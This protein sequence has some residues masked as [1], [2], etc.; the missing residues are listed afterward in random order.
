MDIK[1]GGGQPLFKFWLSA[2]MVL[3]VSGMAGYADRYI[4]WRSVFGR[5]NELYQTLVQ[6][7]VAFLI[8]S[9]CPASWSPEPSWLTDYVVL[10]IGMFILINVT[11]RANMGKTLIAYAFMDSGPVGGPIFLV[12]TFILTPILLPLAII[13]YESLNHEGKTQIRLQLRYYGLMVTIVAIMA[14]ANLGLTSF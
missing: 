4:H 12:F 14:I 8:H 2:A 7:P 10:C 11:W 6:G 1:S 5:L 9:I 3:G 13:V